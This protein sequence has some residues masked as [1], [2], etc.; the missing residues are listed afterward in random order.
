MKRFLAILL[1]AM[2]LLSLAACGSTEPEIFGNDSGNNAA[3]P[4][5]TPDDGGS[6]VPTDAPQ[7]PAPTAPPQ[8]PSPV[9]G[10]TPLGIQETVTNTDVGEFFVD[11]TDITDDVMPP[12]PG[13]WYSHYEA[14]AGKVYIDI[15]VSYKN[16]RTSDQDADE[17]MNGVLV[18]G[19]KYEFRG[20]S[21]IEEDN[22]SDFTYSNITSI[23]PLSTEYLHYLFSV[24]EEVENSDG[25]LVA[26][27]TIDG[28]RY[29]VV[30]REGRDGEV[31]TF[32]PDAAEK[33]GGAVVLGEWISLKNTCEFSVDYSDITNDVMP[34]QPGDWYSHYEA[35][36]GKV[37]VDLCIAYRNLT[38]AGVD[39]DEV[40]SA[41]LTYAGKYEFRGFSMIEEKGRSDF[42]YSNITSISPLATEYVHYLFEVP[43]EVASSSE[44][45]VITFTIGG[46]SYTYTVR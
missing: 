43:A 29:S 27:L 34:P 5:E 39:A 25:S 21:M 12:Q 9:T 17:I 19:D 37:Y 15:C 44:P 2:M 35:E 23:A 10:A 6:N 45:I 14:E 31:A 32:N 38:S 8:K 40:V 41:K 36:D 4:Q 26:V 3:P 13:S 46:N 20:F 30:V 18:F 11:Y 24:P 7:N 22:R 16:L 33:S 42:T 1:V 28:T